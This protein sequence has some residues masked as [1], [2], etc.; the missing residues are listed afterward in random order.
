MTGIFSSLQSRV[1][2]QL[3]FIDGWRSVQLEADHLQTLA[4]KNVITM[5]YSI[6]LQHPSLLGVDQELEVMETSL[7]GV[8]MTIPYSD[9]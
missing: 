8:I 2:V 5:S 9:R 1:H 3:H 4:Y 7:K 6:V